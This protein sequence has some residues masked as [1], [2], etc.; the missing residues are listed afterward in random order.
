MSASTLPNATLTAAYEAMTPGSAALAAK[1]RGLMPSGIAHDSRH[2]D[3]Y[4]IY[5]RRAS[6]P[7][8]WDVDGNKY[9]DYFGGH[10]SLLLGHNHPAVMAAVHAALDRGTHFGA[11]HELEVRW[12]ELI[13]QMVPSAER[14]RFT[15]SGTEATLMALRLARA[16]TGR[17][18]LV[19]FRGHFHGWHDHMTSG[20]TNHFDGS[21]T[22]GVI[23]GIADNVL[24]CDPNDVAGITRIFNDHKDIAAVI[25]EPTGASFGKMPILPSFLTLL[26]D[27]TQQAG[28]VLIFDEVVTGFRVSPGGAQAVCGI[29]PDMTTLAKIMSGGLP[30][31]AVVGRKDILDRL[32]F[33]VT[34]AAGEEKI[35]HMGTFNANP[36]SAA[37]GIA[38]LELVAGTDA[39]ARAN[40]FGETIRG[41][42]NEVLEEEH[43]KWAV[44]G[45]HSSFHIFTNPEGEDIVP[46]Q[47][48]AASFIQSMMNK[49]R[50]EGVTA[51]VRMGLLV[52]GV[53]MNSGPSA[54]ISAMHG[55]EEMAITVDAFRATI[56][57]LKR[58]GLVA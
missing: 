58:E 43:L 27:L 2:F 4:P 22:S 47:F 9:V 28:S 14:V 12:A 37:A 23:D 17:T 30:G 42:M 54:W 19:R 15:S 51:Q 13:T 41:R 8:K 33:K 48:D 45:L 46:G 50:G 11:C 57:A 40:A 32:D 5:V 20:Y 16:F 25:L 1:A 3:P 26:R 21:P 55:E 52:N 36:V 35:A 24:L 18:K 39:C 29:T 53:D 7:V 38:T 31:G 34:K 44:H 6:G 49:P 56:R 10:G